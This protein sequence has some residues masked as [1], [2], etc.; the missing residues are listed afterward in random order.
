MSKSQKANLLQKAIEFAV[1]KHSEQRS[2]QG[3]PYTLHVL[4]VMTMA[5]TLDDKIV[6]VLHDVLEDTD[7]T[8]AD[9]RNLGLSKAFVDDILALTHRDGESRADYIDRVRLRPRA[10]RIKNL[11]MDHNRGTKA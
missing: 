4:E 8:V 5:T 6:A 11:D 1:R 2:K 9:L 10:V 3:D 7:A